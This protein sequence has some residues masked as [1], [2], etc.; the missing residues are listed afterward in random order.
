M[1][2]YIKGLHKLVLAFKTKYKQVMIY[3]S[4]TYVSVWLQ[5]CRTQHG[6]QLQTKIVQYI[7]KEVWLSRLELSN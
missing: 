4:T 5:R 2:A 1:K 3:K 6:C 7:F